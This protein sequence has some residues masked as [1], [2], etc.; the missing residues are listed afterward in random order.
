MK[1]SLGDS[2]S[3]HLVS[4]EAL[5]K[6]LSGP[7]KVLMLN[8]TA[9]P[10]AEKANGSSICQCLESHLQYLCSKAAHTHNKQPQQHMS[11]KNI[12]GIGNSNDSLSFNSEFGRMIYTISILL[13]FSFVILLLMIRSIKRSST[14]LEVESLLDSMRFREELDIQQRQ[15]RRLQKAKNKVTAWLTK[16]NGKMWTSSPQIVLPSKLKKP[17]VDNV[18]RTNSLQSGGSYIPEIVI[19]NSEE[20]VQLAPLG[21]CAKRNNSC[22]PSLSLLYDFGVDELILGLPDID[23]RKNSGATECSE[24]IDLSQISDFSFNSSSDLCLVPEEDEDG[25]DEHGLVIAAAKEQ[26]SASV[27]VANHHHW[28]GLQRP[29]FP[30]YTGGSPTSIGPP[31]TFSFR[32]SRNSLQLA[33]ASPSHG[34]QSPNVLAK[35]TTQK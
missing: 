16:T 22:T 12:A 4:L 35:Y 26:R 10:S 18:N 6:A 32:G 11:G 2:S 17:V 7:S 9:N 30:A 1:E 14:T 24:T 23:Y 28:S 8:S 5:R 31:R 21:P 20:G 13:M 34:H 3:S 15:K 25:A 29:A 27:V 33:I 19:S